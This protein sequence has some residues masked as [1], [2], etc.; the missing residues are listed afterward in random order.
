MAHVLIIDD[1]NWPRLFGE[2]WT[3]KIGNKTAP[4]KRDLRFAS[5]SSGKAK[6]KKIESDE[7]KSKAFGQ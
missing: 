5:T 3:V 6:G 4:K 7:Q 2:F 1:V